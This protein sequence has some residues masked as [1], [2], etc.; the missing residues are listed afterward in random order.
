[1][2]AVPCPLDASPASSDARAVPYAAVYVTLTKQEHLEL[3][4]RANSYRSLHRRAVD[5]ARWREERYQRLLRQIKDHAK[6]REAAL[7]NNLAD[8]LRETGRQDASMGEL[9]LAVALF[10][11]IGEEGRL[12][13][14]IW[15]LTDW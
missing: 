1:M 7:R 8:L 6:H 15:K 5:R 13:P 12:E 4:T 3:L 14:E 2:S 9:K 10:A 11:E